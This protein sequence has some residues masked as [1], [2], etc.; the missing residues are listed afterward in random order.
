VVNA[1]PP[2]DNEYQSIVLPDG[3]FVTAMFTVPL[4]HREPFTAVAKPGKG[5]TVAV[6]ATRLLLKHPV[7]VFR[8]SP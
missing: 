1:V 6:T 3:T 5:F 4:P 7:V 2:L 8:L